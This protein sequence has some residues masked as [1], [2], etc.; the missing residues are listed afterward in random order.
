[1]ERIQV[2]ITDPSYAG[3]LRDLLLATS[4]SRVECVETPD[5][6]EDGVIVLDVAH[7]EGLRER[8]RRPE[9]LVLIART[10]ERSLKQ[11]WES[12]LKSV[13]SEKDPLAMAVLAIQAVQLRSSSLR[14]E[15]A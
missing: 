11:A 13:V 8:P 1:M 10:D 4:A 9:R 2:A 15:S 12:G 6:K 5:L 7:L 3:R 14:S